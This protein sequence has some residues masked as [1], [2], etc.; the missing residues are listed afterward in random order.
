[1]QYACEDIDDTPGL[2]ERAPAPLLPNYG[3]GRI[4]R[5]VLD[6][7]ASAYAETI[8][9]DLSDESLSFYPDDGTSY[10]LFIKL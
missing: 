5:Y 8:R 3:T 1:M 7:M 9:L 4:I 6:V 2:A 10:N